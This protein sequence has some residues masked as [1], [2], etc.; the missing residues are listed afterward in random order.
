MDVA[1][2]EAG[3]LLVVP[4]V[5]ALGALIEESIEVFHASADA[6]GITLTMQPGGTPLTARFDFALLVAMV[7]ICTF[8]SGEPMRSSAG[9]TSFVFAVRQ[10]SFSKT[11]TQL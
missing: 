1:S 3:K 4:T 9:L 6:H 11:D 7:C 5:G 8:T 10:Y 2:I